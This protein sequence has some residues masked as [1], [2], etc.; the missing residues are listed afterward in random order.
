MCRMTKIGI[1][2]HGT[3]AWNK[4]GRAQGSSNIP[5]DEKGLAEAVKLAERLANENWEFIFSSN[6]LRAKQTAEIIAKKMGN[7]ETNLDMRLREVAGGLIEGTTEE[8]RIAK[9][10]NGWRELD[11]GI[12]AA[13]SV[14]ARGISAIN[15]I[16][17]SHQNKN[18]LIVSHGSFIRHILKELVPDLNMEISPSNTSLTTL[19]KLENGWDCELYNCTQHLLEETPI[20]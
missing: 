9:W 13:D 2:R 20:K 18:I 10:G 4:E 14:I 7:K 5:L 15:E 11:L 6:L 17:Q 8:E 1:I 12:E 16:T 19:V 3:T